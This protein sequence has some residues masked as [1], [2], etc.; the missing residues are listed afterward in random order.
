MAIYKHYNP[1]KS[2]VICNVKN[3]ALIANFRFSFYISGFSDRRD[4]KKSNR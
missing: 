2:R 4:E 1:P 3:S